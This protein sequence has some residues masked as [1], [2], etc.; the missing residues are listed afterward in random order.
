ME[1]EGKILNT[2][3]YL[4]MYTQINIVMYGNQHPANL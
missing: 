1:D 4:Q 2:K 3:N